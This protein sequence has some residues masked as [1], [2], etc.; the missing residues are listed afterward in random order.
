MSVCSSVCIIVLLFLSLSISP[1][2]YLSVL[3]TC[4]LNYT[5]D[6]SLCLSVWLLAIYLYIRLSANQSVWP[7]FFCS[8]KYLPSVCLFVY[9]FVCLSVHLSLFFFMFVCKSVC[10][11]IS[12]LF[13]SLSVLCLSVSSM[14]LHHPLEGIT[15]PKY[16]LLHFWATKMKLYKEKKALALNRNRCCHLVLCLQLI[17]FH[18]VCL[19]I[20]PACLS[21][22]P[23]FIRLCVFDFWTH[24]IS[25]NFAAYK[26]FYQVARHD[27]YYK[28]LT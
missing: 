5:F 9:S 6:W 8:F 4:P 20:M 12:L 22:F 14:G 27:H 23:L 2:I 11:L 15:N 26:L 19:S 25:S 18:C 17:L 13:F 21:M 10:V 7:S 1:L 3:L 16:K 28:V 24:S